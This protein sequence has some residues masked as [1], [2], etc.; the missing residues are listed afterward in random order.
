[1]KNEFA[2]VKESNSDFSSTCLALRQ[3]V[4]KAGWAFMG[5]YDFGET[6]AAK[7]FPQGGAYRTFDICH[8]KHANTMLGV[9]P[10]I[11]MC[12]PC[13]ISVFESGGKVIVATVRPSVMM[14]AV[15]GEAMSPVLGTLAGIDD[16]LSSILDSATK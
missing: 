14:P 2:F 12:M 16:E 8:A 6:L 4:E 5:G 7:G 1:M 13:N 3:A 9:E 10:L 11:S 15:F